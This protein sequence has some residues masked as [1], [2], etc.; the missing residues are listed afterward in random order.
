VSRVLLV[1][2]DYVRKS[3]AGP[4]IRSLEL[5][6]QVGAAGH[7][8]TLAVPHS[9]DLDAE[10]FP[11][12]TYD[13]QHQESLRHLAAGADAVVLQGFVL[14]RNPFLRETGA[15]LVVDLYDPF[16]LEYLA[17]VA[18]DATPERF[19]PWDDV[20]G[21]LVEQVRL[22]DFFICASERQRDM[23]TGALTML[24]RVNSATYQAD[25]S[26]RSLIDV[27]PFGLA[28]EPPARSGP[29][30]RGVIEGIGERDFVLLWGG[31]VYNW[32][33]PLTLIRAVGEVAPRHPELR[34]VFLS[35]SHP[36]PDLPE[37]RML[38]DAVALA[39]GLGLT[40]RHVFFNPAWV[41]YKTRADWLLD[42]DVGVS[43]HLDHLETRFSFRTRILDYFWA[44]LPILCTAG[45]TLAEDVE[46]FDLGRTVPAEDVAATAAAIEALAG[47]GPD[48]RAARVERV[49][50]RARALTWERA[51]Q[52]L[53]RFCA[54]P[55]LA[56]DLA[57]L[58]GSQAVPVPLRSDAE[59]RRR[60]R[61][62]GGG[63]AYHA[64]RLARRTVQVTAEE[65]PAGLARAARRKLKRRERPA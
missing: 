25:P 50:E 15:A 41:P 35:A 62:P 58:T 16:P 9:T 11:V 7:H 38:A 55:R 48:S 18:M 8:V 30:L 56:P 65:G 37:M 3:M 53:L 19:P 36:N 44:G 47:E 4:G 64:R 21:A 31:G 63:A 24:G 59:R 10:P 52:P 2:H 54:S 45:D 33:D 29:G 6:R 1:S 5:A 12:V 57:A 23:W 49:R 42:A 20:L 27:V 43:T 34:L 17:S 22:G 32:F 51:V 28:A 39:D 60:A 14:E 40:N 26:L 13:P 46:R 61:P